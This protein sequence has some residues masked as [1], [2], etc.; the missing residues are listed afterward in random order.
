MQ[1]NRRHFIQQS[2]LTTGALLSYSLLPSFVKKS[3]DEEQHI[4]ILHTN[5]MH[6]HL[7]PFL[8]DG[9]AYQGLGGVAARTQIIKQIRSTQEHVLLLDAGD[10]FQGTAYFDLYKGEPEIKAL[11]MM[12]YDAVT[13]GEHDFSAGVENYANMIEQYA[14]FPV[15]I[16]NYD[17]SSTAME[18][19]YLP[20][21]VFQKGTLK[22]GVLGVGIE[23]QGLITEDL[24]GNVK[25][26]DALQ[27]ANETADI[28]KRKQGCDFII[29][30]SHLG[31]RY[32][33]N[34]IS[35][36]ILAKETNFIDL[37]I[38]GHTHR[39]FDEPRKYINKQGKEVVVNQAGWAGIQLGRLD[40]NLLKNEKKILNS[41]TVLIGKKYED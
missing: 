36:E 16:C 39:F 41:K 3:S 5:D 37:I 22:I 19:N 34:K 11:S 9:S 23:L 28:L 26:I 4:T 35:D 1:V 33:D 18:G 6:S 21:K 2:A 32:T 40:Y 24:Y 14:N 12:K 25:Y 8:M 10:I 31:D 7:E 27:K 20:Y 15:V 30:L 29:C 13:I 38:G 17:F